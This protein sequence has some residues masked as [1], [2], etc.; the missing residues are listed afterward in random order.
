MKCTVTPY[1]G[2]LP[3]VFL[4]YCHK[5]APIVYPIIE[6]LALDG[7]RVWYD[8]GIHIGTDWPEIIAN[9]LNACYLCLAVLSKNASNS[10]SCK[11]E[12]NFC[13]HNNFKI[14]PVLIEDYPMTPG[15]AL[16]LS[17]IQQLRMH[18]YPS[19]ES[20]LKELYHSEDLHACGL[21]KQSQN[22]PSPDLSTDPNP[23]LSPNPNPDSNH[24]KAKILELSDALAIAAAEAQKLSESAKKAEAEAKQL[25]DHAEK[26]R[27][28]LAATEQAYD[29]VLQ[30]KT[31]LAK[32]CSIAEVKRDAISEELEKAEKALKQLLSL[33]VFVYSLHEKKYTFHTIGQDIPCNT[34]P[35][36]RSICL[37]F[38][39]DV[40]S[41]YARLSPDSSYTNILL[42]DTG[43]GKTTYVNDLLLDPGACITLTS[44]STISFGT[45]VSYVVFFEKNFAPAFPP[46][47]ALLQNTATGAAQVWG[48]DCFHL[49]RWHT[50]KDGTF[51]CIKVGRLHAEIRYE[52]PDYV[53]Y[54]L[55][56][57]NGTAVNGKKLH[58]SSII[59]QDDDII[60][61]PE[62]NLV[63]RCY[64]KT[65][66]DTMLA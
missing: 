56:S 15:Q 10:H 33:H 36:S 64:R 61:L 51:S 9:H 1:E 34:D 23:D 54:D 11:S 39:S 30:E 58:N 42:Q 60:N 41:V 65:S 40:P 48:K 52:C 66:E 57:K 17:N 32:E 63:F 43:L 45:D 19:R 12:L 25:N 31:K 7:C 35:I 8:N 3:Y 49:G 26:L 59:L 37:T 29:A 62:T 47:F 2:D 13:C 55:N 22:D 4:S 21:A 46:E 6:Q 20:F 50:W 24:L 18:Q 53:L 27:K 5:D 44:P 28:D 38:G 14:L 16:Q